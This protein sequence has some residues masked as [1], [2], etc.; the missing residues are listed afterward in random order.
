MRKASLFEVCHD[1]GGLDKGIMVNLEL[2]INAG[3]GSDSR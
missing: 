1:F 2:S 3:R